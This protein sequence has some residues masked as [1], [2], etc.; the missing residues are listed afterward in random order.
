M[1]LRS[2]ELYKCIYVQLFVTVTVLMKYRFKKIYTNTCRSLGS[3]QIA[4]FIESN[5][6]PHCGKLTH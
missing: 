4:R 2:H 1:S 3:R 5:R 6:E